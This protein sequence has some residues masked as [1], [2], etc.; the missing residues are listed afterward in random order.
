L[1]E[2]TVNQ[3]IDFARERLVWYEDF[4]LAG[5]YMT[6]RLAR[7]CDQLL[8]RR[9]SS[10]DTFVA[11]VPGDDLELSELPEVK[12]AFR[13]FGQSYHTAPYRTHIVVAVFVYRAPRA[14]TIEAVGRLK[15]GPDEEVRQTFLAWTASLREQALIPH[16]GRPSQKSLERQLAQFTEPDTSDADRDIPSAYRPPRPRTGD[17][18]SSWR[19]L[20]RRV[21]GNPW[22]THLVLA[23]IAGVFVLEILQ[24]G[25]TR[26]DVLLALGARSNVYIS[27]GQWWRLLTYQFL[28]I[29]FL[30]IGLNGLSLYWLGPGIEYAFG[31][32][33]FLAI[34][35]GAG[36]LGG[37][38]GYLLGDPLSPTLSAGASGAVFGLFGA[39]AYFALTQPRW[40]RQLALRQIGFIIILN[41]VFGFSQQGIDNL[42]HLGGLAG[43]FLLSV[44]FGPPDRTP[45]QHRLLAGAVLVAGFIVA[46]GMRLV[47]IVA[48]SLGF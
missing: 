6:N 21:P 26:I 5:E 19:L 11:F 9:D 43:G 45:F 37:A 8:I 2:P 14:Q 48:A 27:H 33:R 31:H 18:Q 28:H 41:V 7:Y 10:H 46:G 39:Y 40:A 30:H 1:S 20:R 15:T 16:P 38:A 23:I 3:Y 25:A 4:R 47:H 35:L 12:E 13:D 24:G 32:W 34:Y 22:V 36:T 44:I 42:A 17:S 29:G